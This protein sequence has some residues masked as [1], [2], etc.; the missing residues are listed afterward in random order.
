MKKKLS[1]NLIFILASLFVAYLWFRPV[2]W[3]LAGEE[4]DWFSALRAIFA[5]ENK[6]EYM[7]GAGI[8]QLGTFWIFTQVQEILAGEPTV[9][10]GIFYPH[11]WDIAKHTG[12]A[13][14]DGILSIPLQLLIGVPAFYNLHVFGVIAS[15]FFGICVL[16]RV[17]D[18]PVVLCITFAYLGLFHQFAYEEISMGRPTQMVWIFSCL[19]LIAVFSATKSKTPYRHMIFAGLALSATCLVYWF[20]G[21]AVAFCGA[22]AYAIHTAFSKDFTTKF[23]AGILGACVGL[24]LTIM[25]TWKVSSAILKGKGGE[26]FG[27]LQRTPDY[28]I[29]LFFFTIPIQKI[30]YIHSKNHLWSLV[31]ESGIPPFLLLLAGFCIL[32]PWGWF[33]RLPW[34]IATIISLGIPISPALRWN[35]GWIIT[36][37]SLLQTVFPPLLRCE[38]PERMMVAPTLFLLLFSAM[39][40]S[41]MNKRIHNQYLRYV[42]QILIVVFCISSSGQSPPS[43]NDL[44]ISSFV[45]D[46][47]LIQMTQQYPGGIIDV[48][49]SRSE[50]TYIQQIFHHQPLLGGPGLNRVQSEEHKQ[51][52]ANNT[53]LNGIEEYS[54]Q[55]TT[56]TIWT[57][58]DQQKLIEE[59]FSLIIFHPRNS[60]ASPQ[61]FQKYLGTDGILHQRTK[62]IAFPLQN[63]KSTNEIENIQLDT[64]VSP[65]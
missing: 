2:F 44:R 9:L 3:I 16:M 20:G 36:G 59:G 48:P 40:I 28:T 39:A 33:T 64:T 46:E 19:F 17:T 43:E 38:Y 35:D 56:S 53:V 61:E 47:F 14:L 51:Y 58:Q 63:I 21:V 52:C 32:L 60:I 27:A 29:D 23:Y 50:N 45:Q 54:L 49:L 34:L 12:F 42:V 5:E 8:D 1:S 6:P 13:W 22:I 26:L 41:S 4:R 57:K 10:P 24:G 62:T 18:L 31:M 15:T 37:Q 7:L 30:T 11:G 65:P 25:L 55:G